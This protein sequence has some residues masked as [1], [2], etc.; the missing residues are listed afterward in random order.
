MT[1]PN[2]RLS[3]LFELEYPQSVGVYDS[4]PQAQAAVD[5]LADAKFA[6]QNLAIVGTDLKSVE[7][8]TGRRNWGTVL[9][10]G[11][12]S[13]VSTGLMVA[14]ILWFLQP[15]TN[16]LAL[17]PGAL[18]IGILIG[19]AF[20]AIGYAASRGKRDFNSI[21]QTVANKYEVLCEHKVAGQAREILA[22]SPGARAAAFDP[23]NAQQQPWQQSAAGHGAAG[24][25]WGQQP[26]PYAAQQPEQYGSQQSGQPYGQQSYGEQQTSGQPYGQQPS[27]QPYGRQPYGQVYDP[28]G[29]DQQGYGAGYSGQPQESRQPD[30]SRPEN[31]NPAEAGANPP[32]PDEHQPEVSEPEQSG[33]APASG[34]ESPEGER[35]RD[36]R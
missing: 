8:V 6:V 23:R 22:T 17:L 33:D 5:F 12:Q 27:G 36:E 19:M 20:A 2:P 11:L 1:Q 26:G 7:R 21:S 29:Y 4:Y 34:S 35:P 28:Q 18:L 32:E 25:G 31:G 10:T 13:G 24:A 14:L 30:A 15:S 3:S 9:V 16:P